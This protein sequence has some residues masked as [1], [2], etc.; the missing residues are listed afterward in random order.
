MAFK[1]SSLAMP[2][3]PSTRATLVPPT[4]A[5]PTDPIDGDGTDPTSEFP[6]EAIALIAG[7]FN[8]GAIALIAGVFDPVTT[9]GPEGAPGPSITPG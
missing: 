5:T 8:P 6:T 7:A 4:G 1:L 3:R 9:M 2:E